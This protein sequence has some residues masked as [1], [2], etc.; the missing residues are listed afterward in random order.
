M[1]KETSSI[2]SDLDDG[3]N[4][5]LKFLNLVFPAPWEDYG[6][7]PPSNKASIILSDKQYRKSWMSTLQ[8]LK[9]TEKRVS[10]NAL[11]H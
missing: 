6:P 1:K 8:K 2:T 3:E 5:A 10:Y 11:L 9:Q 7:A 4:L